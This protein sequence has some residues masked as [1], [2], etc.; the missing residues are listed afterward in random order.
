MAQGVDWC[1]IRVS[2]TC[3]WVSGMEKP[4][5]I[6]AIGLL[7]QHDLDLLGAGFRRAFRADESPCFDELLGAIDRAERRSHDAKEATR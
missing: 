6:V 4:E 1:V 2:V 7:T 3:D 5:R